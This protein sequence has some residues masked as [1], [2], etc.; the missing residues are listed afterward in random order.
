MPF[1]TQTPI[2]DQI[3]GR[4]GNQFARMPNSYSVYDG[5]GPKWDS[6]SNYNQTVNLKPSQAIGPKIKILPSYS[7]YDTAGPKWDSLRNIVND[8]NLTPFSK[9]TNQ[10][11]DLEYPAPLREGSLTPISNQI[12]LVNNKTTDSFTIYDPVF[13]I[14]KTTKITGDKVNVPSWAKPYLADLSTYPLGQRATQ[15]G[16]ERTRYTP[17]SMIDSESN[18]F[19]FDT[20]FNVKQLKLEGRGLFD[21]DITD[22]YTFVSV[23]YNNLQSNRDGQV[24]Q[25][26]RQFKSFGDYIR[27]D[28]QSSARRNAKS[29]ASLRL[30]TSNLS[31]VSQKSAGTYGEFDRETYFGMGNLGDFRTST[32]ERNDFTLQTEASTIWRLGGWVRN[33]KTQNIPFRGD[34][35]TA[36]DFSTGT[37]KSI[38]KW[39]RDN[40]DIGILS[41]SLIGRIASVAT[42]NIGAELDQTRDFI[43]FYFLGPIAGTA[44]QLFD[45]FVFRAT[46]NSLIDSFSPQWTPI[47]Y[48]GRADKNYLYTDFERNLDIN[49]SVYAASRDELKPMWRKLNYLSTYTMPEY[50]SNYIM[51]RGK[52]L[53]ITIGDLFINQPVFI[54]NLVYTLA[55]RDTTWE[56]NIEDDITNK[57]VPTRVDISMNLKVLT[58][59]LPQYMGQSYSLYDHK[60]GNVADSSNWLSD[61]KTTTS[62]LDTVADTFS[63]ARGL[64]SGGGS[65]NRDTGIFSSR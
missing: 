20:Y 26:F 37:V 17:S 40:S 65:N 22:P 50:D 45:I 25:D 7:A 2:T 23:P 28:G 6:L 12:D 63:N 8:Q 10:Y 32:S 61:S 11:K 51:Y 59:H 56:I 39:K 13:T 29:A 14:S 48:I 24:L 43:K 38:Y 15:T 57:Q 19:D 27:R 34:K 62:V 41:N 1:I 16:T 49:F 3:I 36:R 4:R 44:N 33:D 31:A 35:V 54:T 42:S 18:I 58:D 30:L 53:R 21:R 64:F 5:Y 46:I 9:N 60:K 47:N 52:Y 55:D